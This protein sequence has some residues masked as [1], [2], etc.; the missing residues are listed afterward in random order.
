MEKIDVEGWTPEKIAAA[1]ASAATAIIMVAR[2]LWDMRPPSQ[3]KLLADVQRSVDA[4][5]ALNNL[6]YSKVEAL[7]SETRDEVRQERAATRR[8]FLSLDERVRLL[9]ASR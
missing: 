3:K 8:M 6:E 4:L 1:I 2:K 7:I 5:R 9:E